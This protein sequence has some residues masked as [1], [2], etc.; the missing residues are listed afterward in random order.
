[1]V[2]ATAAVVYVVMDATAANNHNASIGAVIPLSSSENNTAFVGASVAFEGMCVGMLA[3]STGLLGDNND[4][5]SVVGKGGGGGSQAPWGMKTVATPINLILAV[6]G[7]AHSF[8]PFFFI[9]AR[10]SFFC[11]H[12]K[13]DRRRTNIVQ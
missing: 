5:K 8:P 9:L 13:T 2:G 10:R 1:M 6:G 11:E 3:D 7:P 4:V 12:Q